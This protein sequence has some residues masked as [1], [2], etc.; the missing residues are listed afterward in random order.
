M[1]SISHVTTPDSRE[2]PCTFL[3]HGGRDPQRF[4]GLVNTPVHRGSTIL[5]PDLETWRERSAGEPFGTYG[6]FGNPTTRSLEETV[7]HLEGGYRSII[8][9]SGLAACCHSLLAFLE[10]GD[11]VLMPRSVYGPVRAFTQ[12]VLG[13]FA[14]EVEFYDPLAGGNIRDLMRSNTRVV[15]VESP[16]SWTFEVQDIPAIAEEAHAGGAIVV[17]DNSW[18]SPLYFK[19]FEHGVDVS[20]Q[21]A[22]KYLVGHSDALLGVATARESVWP[23]LQHG[24]HDLGQ[25]AGPDDLY[26]ALRGI[27]TLDVRLRRHWENGVMLAESLL[28]QPLV[29]RVLHPALPQDPGHIIWRRDFTG[30]SGLFGVELHQMDDKVLRALFSR[31]KLFGIGLSWG[32]F[33]SLILPYDKP[34]PGK[35]GGPLLRIH[36]GLESASDLIADMNE[37]LAFAAASA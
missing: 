7:A 33:E 15:Y 37:A 30:A 2:D 4:A 28:D 29:K 32:G 24:A 22:T 31:L 17:M 36:A 11:H 14:I 8:F 3:V 25:T 9:P 34:A 21:A 26:L 20:V 16:G 10:G 27:R 19:P 35:D 6:R 13:R 23:Q 18:A 5:A 12:R 1:K